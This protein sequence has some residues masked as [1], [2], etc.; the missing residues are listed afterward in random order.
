MVRTALREIVLFW[1]LVP[2][3]ERA[4]LEGPRAEVEDTA[5][6]GEGQGHD[7]GKSAGKRQR[8]LR[9]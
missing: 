1:E 7:T 9:G 3:Q 8:L 5:G 4:V 6:G 2:I